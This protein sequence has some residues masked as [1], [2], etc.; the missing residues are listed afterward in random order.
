LITLAL[1]AFAAPSVAHAQAPGK[2][3]HVGAIYLSGHHQVIVDGLR[4][5]LHDL[6][7]EEGKQYVLDQKQVK[8]GDWPAVGQAARDLERANVE[9]IYTVTT[10]VTLG[11][12]QATAKVPIV[13]YVG[14]DPVAAGLVQSFAKPGGRLSGVH[15]L[16]RDLTVKRMEILKEMIP[17]LRRVVT[18]YDSRERISTENAQLARKVAQ[19]MGLQLV[20]R[21]LDSVEETRSV[22]L[23]LASGGVQAY[24]HTPGGT[25][26]SQAPLIIEASRTKKLPTMFHDTSLVALGGLAAYGHNYRE[27]G[28]LSAKHVQRILAGVQPKDLPVENYD[29]VGLALNLRTAREIGLTIP[30]SVRFRADQ[31]IE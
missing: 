22:L 4:Q 2:I 27:I 24:F 30:Q 7:L 3:P 14:V 31:L 18:F 19:Q 25:A 12:K 29:K 5:G 23:G 1:G 21:H 20:E 6:G 17:K 10:Q 16:S 15:S 28:R 8:G 9:V 13:F 26:T 11:T